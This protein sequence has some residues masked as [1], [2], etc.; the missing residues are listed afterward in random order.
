[1]LNRAYFEAMTTV[2]TQSVDELFEAIVRDGIG[3]HERD[4]TFVAK[5]AASAGA[6]DG[7]IDAA[8]DTELEDVMRTRA[9]A[10]LAATTLA[11][12]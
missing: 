3:A 1:M 7:L 6:P 11:A 4:V 2:T 5:M 9:L 12:K 8:L 10:Q